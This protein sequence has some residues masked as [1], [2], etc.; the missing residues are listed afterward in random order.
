[1]DNP[2]HGE[3]PV[4]TTHLSTQVAGHSCDNK[5]YSF[6]LLVKSGRYVLKPV[7]KEQHGKMEIDF[8]RKVS[9]SNE[10]V[11]L[12][13][14]SLVPEFYGTEILTWN[15]SRVNYI[16]LS[17]VTHG[18]V[19]PCVMDIKIG[20][21]TWDP[22]ASESKKQKELEKYSLLKQSYGF[23]IPG[24]QVY[25]ATS[26]EFKKFGKDY[27]K[28]LA[29]DGVITAFK[30]FFNLSHERGKETLLHILERLKKI[31]KWF[32]EQRHFHFYSSSILIA[33]DAKALST[34][35]LATV[36]MIDFAHVFPAQ[37]QPDA[38]YVA[39]AQTL[40]QVLQDV[41]DSC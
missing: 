22:E 5:N 19:Q 11:L 8:Y 10:P 35:P 31:V 9:S 27:G 6:G 15:D 36:N 2:E 13:L 7:E 29:P 41:A 33:Y 30:T 23:C 4:G 32:E 14:K 24:F 18:M 26:G 3:F 39:G 16:V 21:Q 28:S 40:V 25:D 38:N 20:R 17:N 34:F 12:E 37:G 1:M